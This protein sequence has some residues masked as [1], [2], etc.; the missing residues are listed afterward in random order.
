MTPPLTKARFSISQI[1]TEPLA[2]LGGEHHRDV[3]DLADQV[4]VGGQP[5]DC[6]VEEDE[7]LFALIA[8]GAKTVFL[9]GDFNNW[10]PAGH[11]LS[12][13]DGDGTPDFQ[14]E[15]DDGYEIDPDLGNKSAM[16]SCF[17]VGGDDD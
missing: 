1:A 2:V 6:P 10:N 11:A 17:A 3:G 7:V 14:D 16:E 13:D 4:E 12:D 5:G 9:V 15:D 8:P